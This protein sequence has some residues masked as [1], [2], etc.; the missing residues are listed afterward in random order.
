MKTKTKRK[1]VLVVRGFTLAEFLRVLR[2]FDKQDSDAAWDV[3]NVVTALRGPD[4][5]DG[6]SATTGVIRQAVY[7]RGFARGLA[8]DDT[9]D[10]VAIRQKLATAEGAGHFAGHA[11]R[12][13]H[14]LGLKWGENN[15]E[16]GPKRR[17]NP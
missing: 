4:D 17:R 3:W 9:E 12:A 7:G 2:A 5:R 15:G 6:K 14:A 16:V 10:R 1:P 11:E 8:C 13:F